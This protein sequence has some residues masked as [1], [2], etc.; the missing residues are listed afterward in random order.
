[1][2]FR[3]HGLCLEDI[4]APHKTPGRHGLRERCVRKL[5]EGCSACAR[6]VGCRYRLCEFQLLFP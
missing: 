2:G 4:V 3:G 1:M 5:L 6:R